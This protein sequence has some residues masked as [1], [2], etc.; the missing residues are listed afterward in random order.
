MSHDINA[1][2]AVQVMGWEPLT[3]GYLGTDDATPRQIELH[4]WLNRVRLDA[5]GEYFIDVS[6][7]FWIDVKDWAPST[8]ITS[9]WVVVQTLHRRG[10]WCQMRTPF[11]DDDPRCWAGFTPHGM[12]GWN[13]RPDHWTHAKTLPLAICLAALSL[14]MDKA[15]KA[16]TR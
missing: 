14:S 11:D 7:D 6:N 9:A 1:A 3:V 13:G 12:S 2:V 4:D 15:G 16:T 5:V 8:E 10:Y